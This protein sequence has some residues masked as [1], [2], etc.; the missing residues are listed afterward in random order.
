MAAIR[1]VAE[2]FHSQPTFEGAG[3]RLKRAFGFQQLPKF[4]PFLMLDDFR[5]DRRE[6]YQAGFPWHPHRG[7]ETVTYVLA[8]EVEH[9]DSL[10]N[11]GR[12][13]AGDVQWM[14]AGSGIIHQEMPLGTAEGKLQG[15]QLWLNLPAKYKMRDPRYQNIGRASIPVTELHNR[16][17]A[18]V[19]AGNLGGVQGPVEDDISDPAYLDIQVPADADFEHPVKPGHTVF[20]YLLAGEA[21]FS[22]HPAALGNGTVALFKDGDR[23]RLRS[24]ARGAHLLLVSGKP[25][26]EPI[27]WYGPMVMNTHAEIEKALEELDQGTFIKLRGKIPA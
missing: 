19:I 27:S 8:G 10:G 23:I 9:Q 24:G 15:F 5:S 1:E 25:L 6:D 17:Q 18:R 20:A 14:T 7:M 21:R 16:A 13:A 11:Q 2:I 3:V 12:I 22:G 4:D 26:G